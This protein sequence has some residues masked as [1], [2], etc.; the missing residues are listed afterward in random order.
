MSEYLNAHKIMNT[1]VTLKFKFDKNLFFQ[2]SIF[3]KDFSPL[4][5]GQKWNLHS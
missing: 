4:G 5:T 3:L 1:F 2:S